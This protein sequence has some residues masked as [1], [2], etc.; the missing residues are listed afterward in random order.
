M[1]RTLTACTTEVDDDIIAIEEIKSQLKLETKLL[2]NSIGIIACH[3]EFVISGIAKAVCDALPFDVVGTISS[4]LSVNGKADSLLLTIMVLTCDDVEFVKVLTP[5]LL[6]Q[7]GKVIAESYKA[8]TAERDERPALILA[9][10][11]FMS[12]N[13]GDEYVNVIT[14]VSNAAPCFGT[15]AI[16][17]MPDYSNC[18]ML[19]NGEHYSDR[20]S[21][22]LIYGNIH[23]K[24][25]IANISPDKALDKSAIITKSEG[26]V[27][28]ELNGRSVDEFFESLGLT[29]ASEETYA[30][31]SL[32]FLLDYNDGTPKVSKIFVSLTPERYALCAGATPEGSTL[33]IATTDKEDVLLTSE[34]A[35]DLILG[36]IEGASGL[37]IYSC[38]ARSMVLIGEHQY[39]EIDLIN[40]KTA[41]KLPFMM[42]YS[43][44]EFCPT[45]D[46]NNKAINRFHNNAFIA[47]L[48]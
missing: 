4:P 15:I 23:P 45:Q 25:Y 38:I 19:H 9:Y 14:E 48:F 10:A 41:G 24:F 35:A 39:S 46:S 33:N 21:M 27:I 28:M 31:S 11:P 8:A 13:S 42:A 18:F 29:K 32:P 34:Q 3:Y 37:L 6:E 1:I 2:K 40:K 30:M 47:C 7:P 20:M 5:S 22:V 43:G 36:D 16:D 26:H 12:Q 44:G 17:D